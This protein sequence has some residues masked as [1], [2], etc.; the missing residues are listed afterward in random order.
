MPPIT[1]EKTV[2]LD[3][4]MRRMLE[5]CRAI[6]SAILPTGRLAMD[7]DEVSGVFKDVATLHLDMSD[8]NWMCRPDTALVAVEYLICLRNLLGAVGVCV[9][10]SCLV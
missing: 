6:Q 10:T 9:F 2:E 3:G 7:T 8:A 1:L 5:R 4:R